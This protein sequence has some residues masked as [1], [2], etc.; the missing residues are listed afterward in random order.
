MC[1]MVR[2]G[3]NFMDWGQTNQYF[4]LRFIHFSYET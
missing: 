3:K 4:Y 1:A 2:E